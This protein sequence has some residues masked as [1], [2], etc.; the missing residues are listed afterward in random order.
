M[1]E[2]EIVDTPK[3]KSFLRDTTEWS[4]TTLVWAVWLYLLLPLL[5]IMLW[6]L[7]F[8]YFHMEIFEKAGYEQLLNLLG[9][10]GWVVLIVFLTLRLW[11]Y[12][13]Y[14]RFGKK[15]RRKS[16][17]PT[18]VEQLSEF[19][20]VPPEQIAELQ[21]RKEVVWPLQQDSGQNVADWLAKSEN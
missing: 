5:N 20:H 6:L 7:G 3:L 14:M 1:T 11:G 15:D 12:Y 17:P 8:R 4:F 18:T 16:A 19:F 9:K 13:N 10:M 21:S 2:I